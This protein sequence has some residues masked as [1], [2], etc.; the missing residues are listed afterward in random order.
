MDILVLLSLVSASSLTS[1]STMID[2]WLLS[3]LSIALLSFLLQFIRTRTSKHMNHTEKQKSHL[4]KMKITGIRQ[5][6]FRSSFALHCI[7]PIPLFPT[8]QHE[9][10]HSHHVIPAYLASTIA[11]LY[12]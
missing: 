6:E 10:T 7:V 2:G 8:Y 5:K 1:L 3:Q 9:Y 12:L 11:H 4:K